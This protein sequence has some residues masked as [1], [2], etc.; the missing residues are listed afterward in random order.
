MLGRS[1]VGLSERVHSLS[2][3][4]KASADITADAV[5]T[6]ISSIALTPDNELTR[7]G[8]VISV[9]QLPDLASKKCSVLERQ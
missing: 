4:K 8:D 7:D 3:T 6:S 9:R 5:S 2:D 1:Q